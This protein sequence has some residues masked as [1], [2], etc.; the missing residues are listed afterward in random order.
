MNIE[1]EVTH[2]I[3]QLQSKI[4]NPPTAHAHAPAALLSPVFGRMVALCMVTSSKVTGVISMTTPRLLSKV[5][6][7][8]T[9]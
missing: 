5:R 8:S 6:Q 9:R 3:S 7:A 1:Q 2:L 4:S